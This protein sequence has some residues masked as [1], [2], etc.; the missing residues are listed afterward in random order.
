VVVRGSDFDRAATVELDGAAASV[1]FIDDTQLDVT[2]PARG[3]GP[4]LLKV[5]NPDG[6]QDSAVLEVRPAPRVTALSS[7]TM[8]ALIGGDE[9]ALLGENLAFATPAVT[10]DGTPAALLLVS[11]SVVRVQTPDGIAAGTRSVTLDYGGGRVVAAPDVTAVAPRV[12]LSSFVEVGAAELDVTLAG[13]FLHPT[14]LVR[15]DIDGPAGVT[16]CVPAAADKTEASV[17]CRLPAS[18]LRPAAAHALTLEYGI[19]AMGAGSAVTP[20]RTIVAMAAEEPAFSGAMPARVQLDAQS[21]AKRLVRVLSPGVSAANVPVAATIE[22]DGAVG[23]VDSIDDDEIVF[24]L[25]GVLRAG[26]HDAAVRVGS[27]VIA[28]GGALSTF[29]PT[30]SVVEDDVSWSRA[31]DALTLL[32]DPLD[33]AGVVAVEERTGFARTLSTSGVGTL[34]AGVTPLA[35]GNWSLCL[36]DALSGAAFSCTAQA[37]TVRAPGVEVEPNDVDVDANGAGV[38]T[39]AGTSVTRGAVQVGDRDRYFVVVPDGSHLLVNTSKDGG[40][41]CAPPE[42]TALRLRLR[43]G[44]Q[45]LDFSTKGVGLSTCAALGFGG[46]VPLALAAGEYVIDVSARDSGPTSYRFVASVV[47]PQPATC[48]N[49]VVDPGEDA[50]CED[51]AV[52]PC[53]VGNETATCDPSTCR[54]DFRFTCFESPGALCGDGILDAKEECDPGEP[55]FPFGDPLCGNVPGFGPE[56]GGVVRCTASCRLDLSGCTS[57]TGGDARARGRA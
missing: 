11:E 12:V 1:T 30:V 41:S 37:V 34:T 39:G 6:Q 49:G 36:A 19:A 46:E 54:P 47:G 8:H 43:G 5:R 40:S 53:P 45:T 55:V 56:V 23:V 57:G 33:D 25:S 29:V 42:G 15:L 27:A 31:P 50:R 20:E 24:L 51:A 16:S 7:S 35:A 4:L 10:I 52:V 2:I 13:D 48:G 44:A 28:R 21:N 32:I 9:L 26:A 22:I 17:R 3:R 18:R 14:R 38:V